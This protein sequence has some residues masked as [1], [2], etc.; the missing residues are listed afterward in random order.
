MGILINKVK[1]VF[2]SG[3]QRSV[4]AKKNIL[5][6][7][8]LKIGSIVLNLAYVPLL[9]QTLGKE[10]YGIWLVLGSFLS[11][12]NFFDIGLANGLR[13]KLG[14]AL[15]G[16]N[17]KQAQEY[18]STT[19]ALFGIIFIPVSILVVI[20]NPYIP[21]QNVFNTQSVAE[22]T[23]K[24]LAL[25]ALT[26][27]SLRFIFQIIGVI[28]LADQR[29]VMSNLLNV[30]ST[31]LCLILILILNYFSINS[32]V[33][34][35]S[36]LAIVPVFTFIVASYF[37]FKYRYAQLRPR[38][39]SVNLKLSKNLLNLGI[40]FF[41]IQVSGLIVYS[42]TNFLIVQFFSPN[43][44]T[45]YNIGYKY[46][47]IITMLFGIFLTPLWSA[48]TEAFAMHDFYWIINVMRKYKKLAILLSI[49]SIIM[50]FSSETIFKIWVGSA[51]T[52]PFS[53]CTVLALQTIIYTFWSPYIAFLNGTGKIKLVSYMVLFQSIA[54]IPVAYILVKM[55]NIGLPGIVIASIICELPIRIIQPIQYS[56]LIKGNATGIWAK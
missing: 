18:V 29:P 13:N 47:S 2:T 46:F 27:F 49:G 6:S 9:L 17:N 37:S 23:L 41:I 45:V 38:F 56:K 31:T 15:A 8:L 51:I 36:I 26:S 35:V 14:E 34:S 28:F 48:I 4:K 40:H 21:W 33:F 52:I 11:W 5:G 44:V 22:Y 12:M 54:Y 32:L 25:I 43:E 20:I 1:H 39:A 19:Y 7:V 55:L 24:V 3:H 16:N 42:S 10:E 53:L 50:L 30:I